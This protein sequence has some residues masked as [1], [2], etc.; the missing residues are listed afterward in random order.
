MSDARV[1]EA[2]DKEVKLVMSQDTALMTEREWNKASASILNAHYTEEGICHGLWDIA[3]KAGFKGG[4]VLEPAVGAAGRILGA[5]PPDL[6]AVSK[7]EA[8]EIDELSARM[9]ALLYPQT[10][11][12]ACGFEEAII[13]PGKFDL[14]ITNV[15]FGKQGPGVQDGAVEFNLHNYFIAESMKKLKPGGIAILITSAYTLEANDDQREALAKVAELHGA[16]RLPS[17]AFKGNAGTEVTTDIL[18]LRKPDGSMRSTAEGFSQL[19]AIKLTEGNEFRAE[20][21]KVVDTTLINEYYGRHPEMV[22]GEHSL[23]GKLYGGGHEGGQYAVLSPKGAEPIV[24]RLEGAIELLPSDVLSDTSAVEQPQETDS[25]EAMLM[26]SID[27]R[28]GML[29]ARGEHG[30]DFYIVQPNRELI[31]PAWLLSEDLPKGFRTRKDVLQMAG[32]FVGLRDALNHV[33]AADLNPV[34]TDEDSNQARG[35][36]AQRYRHFVKT[37]GS[38]F[39][40]TKQLRGIA[41][42]DS[43]MGSVLS[44]ESA[45]EAA[46]V[47]GKRRQYDITPASIIYKRTL[48]PPSAV[49]K[50]DTVEQGVFVCLNQLGTVDPA[51]IAEMLG[52][53]D[54]ESVTEEILKQGL[55]YRDHEAPA[56]L[57]VRSQYLSGDVL[58]KAREARRA[59]MSDPRLEA[60]AAALE[61]AAPARKPFERINVQFGATWVP[62]HIYASFVEAALN[63]GVKAPYYDQRGGQWFWPGVRDSASHS[64]TAQARIGTPR[65]PWNEVLMDALTQTP[66]KIFDSQGPDEP[67]IF[68]PEA[69]AAVRARVEVVNLAWGRWIAKRED[70]KKGLTDEFNS[71]FNRVVGTSAKGD[72]LTFPGIATGPG[73]LVPRFYQ[74]NAVAR[75]LEKPAGVVAH[76]TGY[77][78]TL[79]GIL[80]AH[81]SKRLGSARKPLMV[82]DSANY[83][84]FVEAYRR[85]YPQDR[86][87]VADDVNFSPTERENFK[88]QACYGEYDCILMSRTQFGKI[89]VSSAT[90]ET[91]AG[92]EIADLRY[93]LEMASMAEDKRSQRKLENALAK[94]QAELAVFKEKKKTESDQGLT[95]EEL[96][97]DLVLVDECHRH[98]KTGFSSAFGHIKGIDTGVSTRGRD[99]L[100]KVR[101][102]QDRRDGKGAIGLSGTPC[103]NTMAEFW[104]MNRLFDPRALTDFSLEY[105]DNFKTALCQ[106]ETRLEMNEAN[107]KFRYVERLSRFTNATVLSQFVRTGAD[108]QMDPTQLGLILPRHESGQVE[109][110]I[111]PITDPVLEQMDRLAAIYAKYEA[112]SGQSKKEMSW[113]PLTLMSMGMAASIDP[114]LVDAAAQDDPESLV[115]QCVGNVARIY[116]TTAA[117]RKTQVIFLDRYRTMNTSVLAKLETK[118]LSQVTIE[119]DDTEEAEAVDPDDADAGAEAKREAAADAEADVKIGT[120]FNLYHDIRD[121]LIATGVKPEEIAIIGEAKNSDERMAIFNQVNAGTIRVVLGSSDKLGIGAN[122]QERLYASHNFD[123]PRNMTPDQQ[124]QRD[125]RIVRSGNTNEAVRVILYGMQDTCT[126]AIWNRIQT[127]RRFIRQGLMGDADELEDVGDVRLDEFKAALVADKRELK[128]ADLK[129]RIRDERMAIDVGEQR[130]RDLMS[131][132]RNIEGSIGYYVDREGPRTRTTLEYL[133]ANVAPFEK[134]RVNLSGLASNC[135]TEEVKKWFTAREAEKK[136]LILEGSMDGVAKE[137]GGLVDALKESE[138][139]PGHDRLLLGTVDINSLRVG[140]VYAKVTF[141]SSG[142]ESESLLASIDNPVIEGDKLLDYVRFGTADALLRNAAAIPTC[143]K[144]RMVATEARVAELRKDQVAVETELASLP[145][146]DQA[147][148]EALKAELATVEK[149]ML[150]HPYI[151]GA[152]RR[153]SLPPVVEES[154]V[155]IPSA[156][157][158]TSAAGV[159]RN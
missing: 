109:F 16:V 50:A 71:R 152:E 78:K 29:V 22:L 9:A 18:L 105:F 157:V 5:M 2:V 40:V 57:V 37:H 47:P 128:V 153:K 88:A 95:W 83:A 68:N 41:P 135:P 58:T 126:V 26:A 136:P 72:Y 92:N 61:A 144:E 84:Q 106:T 31:K 148:L 42:Q 51:Y 17:D 145:K 79:T 133:A 115:N 67:K 87:L 130:V 129:G 6:R 155:P 125:G 102:I 66:R 156:A 116:R 75:F 1:N 8:V 158:R 73:A 54:V 93:A 4:N 103:T 32:N 10:K 44:L 49:A 38:L 43:T 76:G 13:A 99:L 91:W 23:N 56:K 100:M 101:F 45:K 104:N 119:L 127:K 7:T 108:L 30:R 46:A 33:V 12:H 64:A 141:K 107:G 85:V 134:V 70:V 132:V 117:E 21:G 48:F 131:R 63:V 147:Q 39:L 138:L 25:A 137:L 36:L 65:L 94:K 60:S 151:R 143:L 150:D 55:A 96:G 90:L 121:K 77:G 124:E 139:T 15:P 146:A 35:T 149:D 159:G 82:C 110:A 53:D 98:K 27:E 24:K 3:R 69:T 142:R 111:A 52:R 113:V 59:A 14:V 11:V 112:L 122:F 74:K 97:V 34:T 118:P 154:A 62:G 120:K 81:E 140:L 89:P 28:P 114:R 20:S 123:P 19:T 80:I 86:I